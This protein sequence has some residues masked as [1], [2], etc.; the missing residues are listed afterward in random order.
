MK[1]FEIG[2]RYGMNSVCD[3]DCWWFYTVVNRTKCTVTLKSDR[4]EVKTCRVSKTISGI[5]NA[6]SVYPTG[7]YSMAP[8]LSADKVMAPKLIKN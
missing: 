1:K 4:G 5:R 6:E 7:K 3:H 8:V 2:K